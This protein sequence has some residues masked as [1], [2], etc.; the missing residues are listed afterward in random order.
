MGSFIAAPRR[1]RSAIVAG[2]TLVELL[3]V[4]AIIGTL[5][6]LLLPAVQSA[7]ESA[8]SSAC[9]NKLKQMALAVTNHDVA[10]QRFPSNFNEPDLYNRFGITVVTSTGGTFGVGSLGT[11]GGI[12]QLLPFFEQQPAYDSLITVMKPNPLNANDI[13]GRSSLRNSGV[14]PLLADLICPSDGVPLINSAGNLTSY[15]LSGGDIWWGHLD[16]APNNR[17]PFQRGDL[18]RIR[19]KDITDGTSK[20]VMLGE[21]LTGS[22][23]DSLQRGVAQVSPT[24]PST[25]MASTSNGKI[26]SPG[27]ST[28]QPAGFLWSGEKTGSIIFFTIQ[29]PNTIRCAGANEGRAILPTS[30]FHSGGAFVAMCDGAVR[31]VIDGIDT[32]ILD[33]TMPSTTTGASQFGVWG[34][35]GSISGGEAAS[36][37]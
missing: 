10:R 22:A 20:T 34:R 16:A 9:S 37:D 24:K 27:T 7:R 11:Y 35:L 8:R 28:S 1:E 4:I 6:G 26:L 36:L 13:A 30:S 15:R 31:F 19:T 2:F 29:P 23:D 32:G 33:Q 5:V 21:A 17:S 14:T 3:V 18:R 12:F 25:C